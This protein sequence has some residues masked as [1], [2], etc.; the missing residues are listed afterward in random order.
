ME[1]LLEDYSE[2]YNGELPKESSEEPSNVVL[3]PKI[4]SD[5]SLGE[6]SEVVKGK[7]C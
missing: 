5:E 2:D 4:F 6:T 7:Y 1:N 3:S